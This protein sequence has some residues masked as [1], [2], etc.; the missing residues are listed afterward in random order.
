MCVFIIVTANESANSLA[1]GRFNTLRPRQ[2]GRRF[3]DDTIKRI[4]LNENVRISIKFLLKFVPKG[5]IN[6]YP[7][8]IRIMV[9]R[10]SGDKPLSET[11]M[12]I[13]PMH[14]CVTRPQWVKWNFREVIFKLILVIDGW[15]FSCKIALRW[16]QMDLTDEKSTLVQ[17]TACSM[18]PSHY[19]S[20]CWPRS[21]S[22]YG[23]TRPQWVNLA[24]T[25]AFLWWNDL[26][27]DFLGW[28]W[29]ISVLLLLNFS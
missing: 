29:Q 17:V 19:L 5:P 12:V 3:A 24:L 22:P 25:C 23:V 9:W 14:I 6:N 8:L 28:N 27:W 10:R 26:I 16:M 21:M 4:F 2:I 1:S 18:L 13:L 20:Q 7:A 11:M 15:V